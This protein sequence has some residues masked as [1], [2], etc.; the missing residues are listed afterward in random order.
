M[1]FEKS[2]FSKIIS[3]GGGAKN[4]EWLQMQADI[5]S[6]EILQLESE[7]GPGQGAA[8]LAM[9]VAGWYQSLEECVTKNVHYKDSILPNTLATIEYDKV[10][11]KYRKIYKATKEICV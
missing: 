6:C 8:F 11:E 10:Y 4:K 7:Q 9:I 1:D 2:Q 5:F 3:V